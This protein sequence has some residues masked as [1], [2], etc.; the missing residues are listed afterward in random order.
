MKHHLQKTTHE[1]LITLFSFAVVLVAS[2]GATTW[3]NALYIL[4]RVEDAAIVLD[5]SQEAPD[6]GSR[7]VYTSSGR[8]GYDVTLSSGQQVLIERDGETLS[9]RCKTETISQLLDR[10][11]VTLSPLE[12]VAVDLSG[13]EIVLSV[14]EDVT[15]YDQ[16]SE[17]ASFETVRVA[18]PDLLEGTE[19]VVQ[20]GTDGVRTS[21]Y[22]VVWSNGEQISRQFVEEL[23]S[24]AVDQIEY[25]TAKREPAMGPA[26]S[27]A[28]YIKNNAEAAARCASRTADA[29][30]HRC[31]DHDSH[32]LHRRTRRRGLYH[33]HRHL[34]S[35]RYRGG[36]PERHPPGDTDVCGYQRRHRLWVDRC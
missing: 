11:G 8:S 6:L 24:T 2:L 14:S 5:G 22:E 4:T 27:A 30:L 26:L 9:T 16:V 19:N 32:R 3:S 29:E 1:R 15:Y 23:D 36:G 17:P 10:M 12:M 13:E 34:R 35:G 28:W 25:G 20:E 21:I 31:Q 7:M 33:R 18:N